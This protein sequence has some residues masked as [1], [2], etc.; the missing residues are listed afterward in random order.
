M[1][2]TTTNHNNGN[3]FCIH[4]VLRLVLIL[5]AVS[6]IPRRKM[7]CWQKKELPS[8]LST[9]TCEYACGGSSSACNQH[10]TH[11]LEFGAVTCVFCNALRC[12][13]LTAVK[14][15]M[16][17]TCITTLWRLVGKYQWFIPKDGSSMFLQ[18][19]VLYLQVHMALQHRRPTLL[20]Y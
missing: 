16:L 12:E 15:L 9:N 4:L 17:I 5:Q 7:S 11:T 20:M 18:N 3:A 1:S 2:I 19:N 6:W 14:M 10:R 13:A 8:G